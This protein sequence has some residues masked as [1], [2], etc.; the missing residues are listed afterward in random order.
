MTKLIVQPGLGLPEWTEIGQSS[1]LDP[2]GMAR[3]TEAV[4]QSL[5]PGI[6]TITNRLRYYSFFPWLLDAYA[7]KSGDTD[8]KAFFQYQRRAE[9]LFALVGVS[10]KYDT[11]L[12]GANWATTLLARSGDILDFGATAERTDGQGYLKNKG[13][14]LGAIYGPQLREMSL[15]SS[16]TGHNLPV[17]TERGDRIAKAVT[18]TLPDASATFESAI[19]TG[20]ISRS[21]LESISGMKPS[22][23]EPGSPEQS[24]LSAILVGNVDDATSTDVSRRQT[25][26][27][28]LKRAR[29]IA[30]APSAQDLKWVWF[31]KTSDSKQD[32]SDAIDPWAAYQANDL[33]RISYEA[34]LKRA[35]EILNSSPGQQRSIE[36]LVSDVVDSITPSALEG[37]FLKPPEADQSLRSMSSAIEKCGEPPA[38][39]ADEAIDAASHLIRH[40]LAWANPRISRLASILPGPSAFQSLSSELAFVS[41]YDQLP[42]RDIL[43]NIVRERILKRHLWVASRKFGGQLAYTYLFEPDEG[44]LRYRNT[45]VVAPSSPRLEQ[46]IQF[47]LD[48]KLLDENN[49]ISV[50]GIKI[51]AAA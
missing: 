38:Y 35:L 49:G 24:L 8:P 40:M 12:T 34:L 3:P 29:D 5:L 51:L 33:L 20:T 45:F 43:T 16:S 7:R 15:V 11:G 10:G 42:P 41:K 50:H 44:A 4:Y 13:G 39:M 28:I 32:A 2:L 25:M 47:L 18:D 37:K 19:W 21:D 36:Q 30:S 26:I 9:A 48:A 31:G 6:S 14:A 23:I 17:P 1:G 27:R 22:E 46:A